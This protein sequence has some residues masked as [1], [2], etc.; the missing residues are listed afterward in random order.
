MYTHTHT[1]THSLLQGPMHSSSTPPPNTLF[2]CH[3]PMLLFAIL[4]LYAIIHL[5][6]RI[7]ICMCVY[8][9]V[10][11]I[12]TDIHTHAHTHTHIR[13]WYKIST[14]YWYTNLHS[15]QQRFTVLLYNFPT[16]DK[17]LT[18]V[19]HAGALVPMHLVGLFCHEIWSLL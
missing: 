14:R 10:F 15:V 11:I 2:S 8:I 12:H 5:Y 7:C 17:R 3:E 9:Y 16:E 6:T 19:T 18:Q 1:H 4:L 13:Y